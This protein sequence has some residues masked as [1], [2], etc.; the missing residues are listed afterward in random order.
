MSW[1]N[2]GKRNSG[3]FDQLIELEMWVNE[4]VEDGVMHIAQLRPWNWSAPLHIEELKEQD[5]LATNWVL[6][7]RYVERM[8]EHKQYTEQLMDF[9]EDITMFPNVTLTETVPG[10][11]VLDM[12]SKSLLQKRTMNDDGV[13]I[14]FRD[15]A[16]SALHS[17]E[18]MI[19]QGRRAQGSR[20]LHHCYVLLCQSECG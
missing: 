9:L 19:S 13:E 1:N 5:P 16:E 7:D 11:D 8:Q 6:R 3:H 12:C 20:V 15:A 18:M 10:A 17:C 14:Y 4:V 2:F